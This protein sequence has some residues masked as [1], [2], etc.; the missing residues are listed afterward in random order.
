MAGTS[1]QGILRALSG[2]AKPLYEASGVVE[3][4]VAKIAE[5]I[6][7][8][9][10]GKVSKDNAFLLY[11]DTG[12]NITLSGGPEVF[13]MPYGTA[14]VDKARVAF[15][16]KGNWWYKGEY[17][18]EPHANGA[19]L[20]LRVYNAAKKGRFLV[21]LVQGGI[22]ATVGPNL[23]AVLAKI[24]RVFGFKTQRDK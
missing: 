3:A 5:L 10:A 9:T 23:D 4:P 17:T 11:N 2:T 24:T 1:V 19:L 18:V 12:D 8:V 16:T 14:E 20:V 7:K 22:A 15:S 21:A 6:T 13:Q